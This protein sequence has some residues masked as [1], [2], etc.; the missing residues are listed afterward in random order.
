[1]KIFLINH[2]IICDLILYALQV[3]GIQVV[4]VNSTPKALKPPKDQMSSK[5]GSPFILRKPKPSVAVP[6]TEARLKA[7]ILRSITKYVKL[8]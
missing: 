7:T 2:I 3:E 1:M 6:P 4:A 5:T 8:A